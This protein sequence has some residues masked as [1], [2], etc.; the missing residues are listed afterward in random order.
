MVDLVQNFA[1]P[2]TK[3]PFR[4]MAL[5]FTDVADPPNVIADA[6]L[7]FVLPLQ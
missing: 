1:Q 5:K 2:V 3:F 7:L 4:I 6:V